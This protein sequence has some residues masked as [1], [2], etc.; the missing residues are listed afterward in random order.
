[1][2]QISRLNIPKLI[3]ASASADTSGDEAAVSWRV[4]FE[5]VDTLTGSFSMALY[6]YI[7]LKHSQQKQSFCGH[8]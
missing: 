6:I 8:P 3:I 2:Y 5:V 4:T 7:Y 1:M